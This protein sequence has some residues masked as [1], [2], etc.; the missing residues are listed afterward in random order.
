LNGDIF[1][2]LC[3]PLTRFWR[4][5]HFWSKTSQKRWPGVEPMTSWS[6]LAPCHAAIYIT[7]VVYRR[8]AVAK[9]VELYCVTAAREVEWIW[10]SWWLTTRPGIAYSSGEHRN[11]ADKT[12]GRRQHGRPNWILPTA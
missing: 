7:V 1:S 6:Q 3:R 2:D 8:Q 9:F 10:W 12:S 11:H 5:R 4:S